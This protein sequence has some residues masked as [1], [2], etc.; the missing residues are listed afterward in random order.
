[1]KKVIT[2]CL[3]LCFLT[4]ST[5]SASDAISPTPSESARAQK[6]SKLLTNSMKDGQLNLREIKSICEAAKGSHLNLVEK[7]VLKMNKKKIEK[8][9]ANMYF[10]G[11]KSQLTAVLLAFFLGVLGIHRFYLGYTWQGVVQLLTF[12]GLGIWSL[13]DF[14]RILT[15]DL[16]PKDGEYEKT[17]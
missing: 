10:A 1:M 9:F 17:L 2:I 8:N 3:S 13:I 16:K 14:I 6:V 11:G 5:V 4:L 12:G 15:G 7:T